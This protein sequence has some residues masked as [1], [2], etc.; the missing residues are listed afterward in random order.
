MKRSTNWKFSQFHIRSNDIFFEVF[1]VK[2][3]KISQKFLFITLR[4]NNFHLL[5]FFVT[6]YLRNKLLDSQCSREKTNGHFLSFS[7]LFLSGVLSFKK[8]LKMQQKKEKKSK[9][10]TPKS[11]YNLISVNFIKNCIVIFDC[12]IDV[13]LKNRKLF[14]QVFDIFQKRRFFL[15]QFS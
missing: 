1:H 4:K 6:L 11:S 15:N 2:D 5:E 8:Y 9:T 7:W 13:A 12:N 10:L 3:Q 14:V